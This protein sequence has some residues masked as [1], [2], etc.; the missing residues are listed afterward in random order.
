VAQ[1]DYD[2]AVILLDF[3]RHASSFRENKKEPVT[4]TLSKDVSTGS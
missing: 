2:V 4:N 1:V 3:L